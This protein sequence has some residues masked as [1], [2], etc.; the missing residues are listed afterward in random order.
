MLVPTLSDEVSV[1]GRRFQ[2]LSSISCMSLIIN[3]MV[4]TGI[5][6]TPAIIFK[7]LEGNVKLYLFLWLVGGIVIFSGFAI[8][9]EF[10]LNLPFRNGGE[11][12]Y[13][14]RGFP[15]APKGL[16]GCI[17]SFLIVLLGFSSGNSYAFGKYV[18]YAATGRDDGG[19]EGLV[20]AIGVACI[21]GCALLHVNFSNHGTALFNILGVFKILVL[22]LII[23]SG[24]LVW[25]GLVS[26][27]HQTEAATNF[28][29][30]GSPSSYAI[31]AALLEI[32]Y[33]FKGWEN[34]NY[35][36]NEM[37]NPY[38]VLVFAAPAAV[39]LVTLLYFLVILSY[40]VVIPK[41][42]LLDSGVLVAGIFF[43]KIFGESITSR[44][45]PL[46]ISLSNLGNVLVVCFAHAHVNQELAMNN[47]LPFSSYFQNINHAI[48]LHW[49]VTVL[50]L[51]VPPSQDIY[52]FVVNLY[53]Y[54]GTWINVLLTVGLIYLKL[55]SS[56]QWG[57][58]YSNASPTEDS[59]SSFTELDHLIN[60]QHK[61]P[62]MS[63]P[64]IC[65]VIFLLANLFLAIFPFV[66]PPSSS[67]AA[68]SLVPYWCFPVVG[69]SV[70][71]MGGAWFFLREY[72]KSTSTLYEHD[73]N[74]L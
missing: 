74:T 23:G 35:V 67:L 50:V 6:S 45:L 8:F 9:L 34:A 32:I 18:V 13:L 20:K 37:E 40:L 65:V 10:A 72:R 7:Y 17:Y 46:V 11:K 3:K 60:A 21:T 28:G 54:P 12:N 70:L 63:A 69:T 15:R 16:L 41:L 2:K 43:T 14:I 64:T 48:W 71:L 47:Y 58:D 44:I 26:P 55:N 39:S 33:S 22:F 61:C 57:T 66:P 38:K 52:E 36:L 19:H 53:I 24:F 73:Y 51:V 1:P 30:S 27:L 56:E 42:E 62:K 49:F 68:N 4:G 31:A 59:D 29:A 5:F 25:T